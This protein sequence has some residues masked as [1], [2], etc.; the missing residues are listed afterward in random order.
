MNT[1]DNDK[2]KVSD[3]EHKRGTSLLVCLFSRLMFRIWFS[4]NENLFERF[5]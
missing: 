1:S 3:V 2:K 4:E 5:T